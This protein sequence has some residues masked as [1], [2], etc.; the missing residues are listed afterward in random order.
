MCGNGN[1]LA[2]GRFCL[3][4]DVTPG[5]MNF[6]ISPVSAERF[7]KFAAAQLS[8]RFHHIVRTSSRTRCNRIV[9]GLGPS[10]KYPSTA[11]LTI[12][13]SSETGGNS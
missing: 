7:G 13:R 9:C 6:A 12:A 1:S 8:R 2:P 4:N 11:P 10:K 3:Q 5:L